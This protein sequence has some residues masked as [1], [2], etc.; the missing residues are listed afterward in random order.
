MTKYSFELKLKA[1]L[2]YE[3]GIGNYQFLAH[4]YQV[5]DLQQITD[6]VKIYRA[7]GSVGLQRKHQ[8]AVYDTQFKLNA[9]NLYLTSKKSYREIANQVGM[10]NRAVLSRWVLDYR[11]KGE[12]AFANSR[13]KP[14]KEPDLS[15][16]KT[17]KKL[18]DL[19]EAEEKLAELE[20]EV[21]LLRIENEYL[22]GLRRMRMEQQAKE[23]PSLFTPS[24]ENSSSRSKK[25]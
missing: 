22:K 10:T 9:V 4:K 17:S 23:N 18:S 19:S 5:K 24:N 25:F 8:Y 7:F 11:E 14:R 16:Q 1:V 15:K 6:W 12:S 20:H 3:R 21:L 13:R 2:D